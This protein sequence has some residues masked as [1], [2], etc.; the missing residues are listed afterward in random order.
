M[1]FFFATKERRKCRQKLPPSSSSSF[2]PL[3]AF[4]SFIPPSKCHLRRNKNGLTAHKKEKNK[5]H[6]WSLSIYLTFIMGGNYGGTVSKMVT[7]N[8]KGRSRRYCMP[9]SFL[10]FP[11]FFVFW[12]ILGYFFNF[13]VPKTGLQFVFLKLVFIL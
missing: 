9:I 12:D 7:V 3:L 11:E 1:Y 5:S 6:F 13:T 8:S 10:L 2:P 4:R